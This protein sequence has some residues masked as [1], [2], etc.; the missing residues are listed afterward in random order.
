MNYT[1]DILKILNEELAPYMVGEN[2]VCIDGVLTS[3]ERIN[4]F[5]KSNNRF[6]LYNA[7]RLRN[8]F[9]EKDASTFEHWAY[10]YIDSIVKCL[11]K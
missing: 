2:Q 3:A 10:S 9:G 11:E 7:K 1:N 8:Y 4:E 5:I 6:D